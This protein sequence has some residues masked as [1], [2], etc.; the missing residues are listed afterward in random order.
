MAP[1]AL[2]DVLRNRLVSLLLARDA[3]VS[4]AVESIEGSVNQESDAAQLI[5]IVKAPIIQCPDV[6]AKLRSITNVEQ[7][8]D[9]HR[10]FQLRGWSTNKCLFKCS[11]TAEDSVEHYCRCP[12]VRRVSE[13]L[14]HISYAPEL[15]LDIYI[16]IYIYISVD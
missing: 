6:K 10:R 9:T 5:K 12:V 15:G 4:N 16:Y 3:L 14:F 7:L 8:G 13:K 1:G 11:S 2:L